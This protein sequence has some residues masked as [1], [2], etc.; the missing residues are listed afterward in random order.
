MN[1]E[2]IEEPEENG[3]AFMHRSSE[4]NI[5]STPYSMTSQFLDLEVFDPSGSFLEPASGMG[6]MVEVLNERFKNV[7]HYD[8]SSG[9]S[10]YDEKDKY[11]YV[12]TN[13]PYG[14]ESDKFVQKARQVARHKFAFLLRTN[15]LSGQERF[16]SGV[17]EGLRRVYVFTRM[18]D[19]RPV[20]TSKGKDGKIIKTMNPIRSDGKYPTAG[21]V[22]AWMV[23]EIGYTGNPEI[24]WI[25]NQEYV[26]KKKEIK[27][28]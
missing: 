15:Y 3:K 2:L 9:K 11:D 12:I 4:H 23:W 7:K 17:F 21:I 27:Q 24:Q 28:I 14:N 5:F 26:L 13:P 10:F 22:Y 18:A 25:D 20:I 16:E 8:I 6:H 19:L 1:I